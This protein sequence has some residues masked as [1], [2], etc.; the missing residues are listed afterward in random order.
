MIITRKRWNKIV[1]NYNNKIRVLKRENYKLK[2]DKSWYKNLLI[3]K[4]NIISGLHIE[5]DRIWDYAALTTIGELDFKGLD[6]ETISQELILNLKAN[7]N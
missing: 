7:L 1:G 2:L 4:K 6:N 3:V 5:L